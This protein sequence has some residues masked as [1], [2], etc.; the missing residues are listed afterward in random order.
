MTMQTDGFGPVMPQTGGKENSMTSEIKIGQKY[1]TRDKHPRICTV[2]DILRTYNN[3][4]QLVSV[5]YVTQHEFAGQTIT[6]Y[7]VP[8]ATIN[9][10]MLAE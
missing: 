6:D 4:G 8:A 10:G 5:A 3:A 9:R 2:T 1:R 7:N